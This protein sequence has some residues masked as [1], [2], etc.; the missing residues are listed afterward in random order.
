MIYITKCLNLSKNN[1]KKN[2]LDGMLYSKIG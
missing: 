1:N 2:N